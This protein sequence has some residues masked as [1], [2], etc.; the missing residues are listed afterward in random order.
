V[1]VGGT[2]AVYGTFDPYSCMIRTVDSCGSTP[3]SMSRPSIVGI[4]AFIH[5]TP[6]V[7]LPI[8]LWWSCQAAVD[9]SIDAPA[10][11]ACTT[12]VAHCRQARVVVLLLVVDRVDPGTLIPQA[13]AL[14]QSV[15]L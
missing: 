9:P 14:Y 12:V 15:V 10:L 5:T 3:S 7:G 11:V 6:A 8:A 13:D 2:I 1:G 4:P